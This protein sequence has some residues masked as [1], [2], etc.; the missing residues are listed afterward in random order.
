MKRFAPILGAVVFILATPLLAFAA[1]IS[2]TGGS[3]IG[4]DVLPCTDGGHWVLSQAKAVKSATLVVAGG[5]YQMQRDGKDAYSADS[6]GPIVIGDVAVVTYD[7]GGQPTLTLSACDASS[8]PTPTPT[9]TPSPSDS[10]PPSSPPPSGQG[11]GSSGQTG[12]SGRTPTLHGGGPAAATDPSVTGKAS[13]HDPKGA[14]TLSAG[15][16]GPLAPASSRASDPS[17]AVIRAADGAVQQAWN[18]GG[19]DPFQDVRHPPRA[20]VIAVIAIVAIG[21]CGAFAAR[22]HVIQGAQ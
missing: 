22:H 7:G 8:S 18:D 14:G 15:P 9:P 19:S 21:S 3:G 2:W 4:S 10:P 11:G 20:L 13:G 5:T 17:N 1:S 16:G 6:S 12:T